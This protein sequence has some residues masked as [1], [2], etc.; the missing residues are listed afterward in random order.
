MAGLA[1][2]RNGTRRDKSLVAPIGGWNTRDA[3]S[4]M[5]ET[6][7]IELDNW[8][9]TTTGLV[10]RKG[11]SSFCTGLAS[12]VE[13]LAEYHV[14]TTRKFIAAAGGYIYDITSGSGS[15]LG[16]SFGSAKWQ[17]ANF[18]AYLHLVNGVDEPQSYNGTTLAAAG[19]T[20]SGLTTT[21]LVGVHPYKNRLYF[22][23]NTSQ[24][25]WYGGV[26]SITGTLTKFPL[27]RLGNKG[28]NLIAIKSITRDG[29]SGSDD[30]IAFFMSSGTVI[31]YSGSD[32]SD[33][34]NWTLQGIYTIGEPISG[35]TLVETKG[36]VLVLT[37]SDAVSLLQ[38]MQEGGF[39]NQPSK[40]SGAV[41]SAAKL[42][43]ANLGWQAVLYPQG[44]MILFNV[45][46]TTYGTYHQYVLNTITGA[47]CRFRGWNARCF[48]LY[49]G[50]LYFGGSGAVYRADYLASDNGSNIDISGQQAFSFLG[51][52]GKKRLA[53]FRPILKS[54]GTVPL[55][56]KLAFDYGEVGAGQTKTLTTSGSA[57]DTATWDV[58]PWSS[59][60]GV[61]QP[62]FLASGSGM[63]VS[64]RLSTSIKTIQLEWFRT[65]YS[66]IGLSRF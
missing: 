43:S 42:Y 62:Q 20:G 15:S 44:N 17:T 6:D 23:E 59:E 5:P 19:W 8:F 65:D 50:N 11:Y 57:W 40:L 34:A 9:P 31:V 12:E 16:S 4:A 7:A 51:S 64:L 21:N 18:N 48:G 66:Y 28:G 49:N 24:D 38:A 45:P 25:F 46:I 2:Q 14:G 53:R 13:T 41:A 32:P 10:S 52:A 37:K 61:Y 56:A 55:T 54:L 27:S 22:W 29:G 58:S 36:D 39:V 33:A 1:Q 35:R 26:N 63:A 60:S 47:A 3:V 30:L